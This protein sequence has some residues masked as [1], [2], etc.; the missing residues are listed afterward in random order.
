MF[1]LY[2]KKGKLIGKF[3]TAK[4]AHDKTGY[5]ENKLQDCID[6]P[7]M[8]L[9]SCFASTYRWRNSKADKKIYAQKALEE[10]KKYYADKL[11][12]EMTSEKN[13]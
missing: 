6:F 12:K 5:N 2:T 10:K 3:E 8:I 4:E 13:K 9:G 11:K 7:G 1:Y